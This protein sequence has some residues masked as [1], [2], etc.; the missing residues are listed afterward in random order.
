MLRE[1]EKSAGY[2]PGTFTLDGN[3]DAFSE[4]GVTCAMG[5][6]WRD[7]GDETILFHFFTESY[8]PGCQWEFEELRRRPL[9]RFASQ[10]EADAWLDSVIGV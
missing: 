3:V 6:A 10:K 9:V 8:A 7:S 1:A 5:E 4:D 2:P